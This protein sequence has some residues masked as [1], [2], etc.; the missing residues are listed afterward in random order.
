MKYQK[1]IK[2]GVVFSLLGI[3]LITGCTYNKEEL[4]YP[5]QPADCNTIPAKFSSDVLPLITT[6]CAISNCHD[7]TAAGGFIFSNYT[8]I[9]SA[10]DLI[11]VV[12]VLQKT[13]PQTGP[14][15]SSEINILKCWIDSGAPNN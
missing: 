2:I 12:A 8:Q 13:M 9:S 14:L 7:A 6:K 4:L 11:K 1:K 15:A 3:I 5:G 10:K